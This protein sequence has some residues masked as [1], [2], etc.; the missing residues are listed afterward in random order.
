MFT[1]SAMEGNFEEMITDEFLL[2]AAFDVQFALL[3]PQLELY[4]PRKIVL[5]KLPAFENSLDNFA[6]RCELVKFAGK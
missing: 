6:S 2:L 3:Q 1:Y 4:Q 5:R